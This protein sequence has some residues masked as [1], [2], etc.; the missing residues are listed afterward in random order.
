MGSLAT[1]FIVVVFVKVGPLAGLGATAIVIA[2]V[3][4]AVLPILYVRATGRSFVH[5]R[6]VLR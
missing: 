1:A 4:V 5:V 6:P 3:A 2:A